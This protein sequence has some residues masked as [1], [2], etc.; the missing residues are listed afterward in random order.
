M[1][2]QRYCTF[3]ICQIFAAMDAKQKRMPVEGTAISCGMTSLRMRVFHTHGPVCKCC[4][5]EGAYFAVER[6]FHSTNASEWHFNLYSE[7]GVML[8]FDHVHPKSKGGLN[9]LSNAQTLC[10]P[11]NQ[12]KSDT[13][14][15]LQ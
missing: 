10:Y 14:K 12:A 13:V 3:P 2:Y 11:C 8:T 9:H 7:R 5:E 15:V 4:G 6:P 1:Y